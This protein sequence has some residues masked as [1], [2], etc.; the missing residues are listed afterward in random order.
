MSSIPPIF[1]MFMAGTVVNR[2]LDR[3]LHSDRPTEKERRMKPVPG[4]PSR[5]RKKALLA[6]AGLGRPERAPEDVG[7]RPR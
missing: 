1:G 4:K 6:A 2:L 3:P 5:E 7:E